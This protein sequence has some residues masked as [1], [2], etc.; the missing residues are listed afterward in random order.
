M[1]SYINIITDINNQILTITIDREKSLNA[2]NNDLI[3]SIGGIL[4]ESENNASIHG[5]IITGSGLKAFAAGADIKGFPSLDAN[6]GSA[7]SKAGHD[8]FNYIENYP[9][10]VVAAINGYALGGGLELAMACHIRI[11]SDNAVFG[12]PEVKLGLIPGY[13]GTQRLA[14]LI[15]KGKAME[16][17]L[18]GNMM[19]A[20]TAEKLG[21][22][23]KVVSQEN[24]TEECSILIS[25]IAKRGPKAIATAIKVI[26]AQYDHLQNGYQVEIDE[27]GKL[28]AS[29][30]CKEGVDAFLNKREPNF[31]K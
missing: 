15:G 19:D 9:K 7:L 6:S 13:G 11:A 2:L 30:E 16:Y 31:R 8:V 25:T 21:L 3:Q 22:V 14:Q 17:I 12:M 28:M 24:L 26:N 5:V 29:D 1:K 27:F 20:A 18:T 10:P 4:S 23:N